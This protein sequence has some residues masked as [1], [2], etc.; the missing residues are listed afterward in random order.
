MIKCSENCYFKFH[1]QKQ[2][3]KYDK[4]FRKL[5]FQNF[6]RIN[7]KFLFIQFR[8]ANPN[9]DIMACFCCCC[10]CSTGQLCLS[11]YV[12]YSLNI[13]PEEI[14]SKLQNKWSSDVILM[15]W[16]VWQPFWT[17]H[18]NGCPNEKTL[19]FSMLGRIT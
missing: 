1:K 17:M 12:F 6:T 13:L 11:H 5:L 9:W 16:C 15:F 8:Y 2:S 10:Y 3:D 19:Q 18:I 4:A 7:A 14:Y